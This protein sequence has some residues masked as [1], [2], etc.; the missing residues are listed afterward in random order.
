[1]ANKNQFGSKGW[2]PERIKTL[3][4]KTFVITGTTIGTGLGSGEYRSLN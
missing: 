1:M 2:T 3:K 4:G